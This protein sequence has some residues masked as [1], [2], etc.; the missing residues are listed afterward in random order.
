MSSESFFEVQI[1]RAEENALVGDLVDQ[2]AQLSGAVKRY[3][4]RAGRVAA[5]RAARGSHL[6]RINVE[7]LDW[8]GAELEKAVAATDELLREVR[9][10]ER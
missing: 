5:N 4:A 8:V 7:A 9:E 1:E 10:D 3:H 6:S 2:V